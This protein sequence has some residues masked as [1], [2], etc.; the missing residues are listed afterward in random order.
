[1]SMTS[2]WARKR[3]S[4]SSKIGRATMILGFINVMQ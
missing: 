4:T 1:L 2:K 3:V